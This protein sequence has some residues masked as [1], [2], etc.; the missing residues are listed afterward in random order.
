[1]SQKVR[2]VLEVTSKGM[3]AFSKA[4]GQLRQFEGAVSNVF[5]KIVNLQNVIA[6]AAVV[7]FT[8]NILKADMAMQG[9]ENRL[10]AAIGKFTST[11]NELKYVRSESD[12]LGISF[13]DLSQSY[14]GF[15]A[16]ATRAGLQLDDV[17]EI[18]KNIAETSVSLTLSGDKTRMVFLALEQMASK[19]KVSMEELRRQLGEH[20]PG[21]LEIAARSMGMTTAQF[22]KAISNGEVFAYDFLPKFAKAIRE[23]LGGSFDR[24]SKQLVANLG[25]WKTQFFLLRQKAGETINPI[26]NKILVRVINKMNEWVEAIERN[27][28]KISEALEK[29]PDYFV[30]IYDAIKN[31]VVFVNKHKDVIYFT[32]M[33]AGIIKVITVINDFRLAMIAL[34]IVLTANPILAVVGAVAAL[35]IA[36]SLT[37]KSVGD[38]KKEL[39]EGTVLSDKAEK[40]KYLG[41]ALELYNKQLESATY[42]D[43]M[44]MIIKENEA[45]GAEIKN[46]ETV[47]GGFG[48][49]LEGGLLSKITTVEKELAKLTGKASAA[50]D[51]ISGSYQK[52]TPPKIDKDDLKT[53]HYDLKSGHYDPDQAWMQ[54]L[55][56]PVTTPLKFAMPLDFNKKWKEENKLLVADQK[57]TL[58]QV[59][60]QLMAFNVKV[61]TNEEVFAERRKELWRDQSEYIQSSMKNAFM[62]LVDLEGT[63]TEKV[64]SILRG[65]YNMS[66]SMMYDYLA[67]YIKAKMY[68]KTVGIAT[69]KAKQAENISTA[70]TAGV[71]A[72][73]EGGKS[74]A[75][76]PYIGPV[77]AIAA[78]ATI[79]GTIISLISKAKK[80]AIGTRYASSGPM[81]VG[82]RGPEMMM[83]RGGESI[84]SND[85]MGSIGGTTNININVSGNMDKE[86]AK[87]TISEMKKFAQTYYNATRLGY[88]RA[89][90]AR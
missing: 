62:T 38:W 18:F 30:K 26:A 36:I 65:F 56:S 21:A 80:F 24:A 50:A 49:S 10:D 71:G 47:L 29:V 88:I 86:T 72:A 48:V 73:A 75:S 7:G 15:S 33:I 28:T 20:L 4:S 8:R 14:A 27:K 74:V 35:G 43:T 90:Y 9:I 1:M 3:N 6:G 52:I 11:T 2:V 68:E 19:G 5:G 58:Q 89:S 85:K 55:K 66:M 34:N 76:I 17:R 82:E 44:G 53:G 23:E 12:R 45:L 70:A 31:V 22:N 37:S 77:L 81:I 51:S 69:E 54:G 57:E 64:Q 63:F 79:F 46:L 59:Y 16:S 13:Q 61:M 67:E 32:L 40:I 25:R 87:M 39:S 78:F 83:A 84:I 42:S 41:V 60:D